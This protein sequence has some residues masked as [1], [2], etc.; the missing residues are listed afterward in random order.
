MR[1]TL[2]QNLIEFGWAVSLGTVSLPAMAAEDPYANPFVTAYPKFAIA[3]LVLIFLVLIIIYVFQRSGAFRRS[4]ESLSLTMTDLTKMEQ[5]GLLTPEEARRVREVLA[6][7]AMERL[8]EKSSVPSGG[9]NALLA[10]PEVIRLRQIAEAK[11]AGQKPPALSTRESLVT[12]CSGNAQASSSGSGSNLSSSVDRA[13]GKT[14]DA[15]LGGPED[16]EDIPLPPDVE[17]LAQQGLLTPEEVARVK[18]RLRQ[19]KQGS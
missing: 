10:D 1:K 17:A 19:K 13:V 8:S 6:R 9:A 18:E 4:D 3:A 12:G 16:Y 14:P 2:L 7:R 5:K 11:R 15:G